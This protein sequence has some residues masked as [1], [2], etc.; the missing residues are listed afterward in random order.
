MYNSI[1]KNA[2]GIVLM[3]ISALCTAI[4]QLCWKVGLSNITILAIG[5]IMYGIGAVVMIIAFKFGKFSVLHPMLCFGYV[6]STIFGCYILEETLSFTQ[7]IGISIII[8]GVIMIG[9]GDNS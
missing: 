7:F 6:F 3:I 2:M 1:K 8:I 4:G 5:F 9:G